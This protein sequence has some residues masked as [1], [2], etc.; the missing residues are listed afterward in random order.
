MSQSIFFVIS[1]FVGPKPPVRIIKSTS[2]KAKSIAFL[3]LF[4]ESPT[5][6]ILKQSI[7]F[8]TNLSAIQ[9]ELEF[10]ICP[11]RISSPI[12]IISAFIKLKSSCWSCYV[13]S[14]FWTNI[15][16]RYRGIV[17]NVSC[18]HAYIFR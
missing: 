6:V 11:I 1:S 17:N 12:V 3:I 10:M 9:E 5:V 4:I 15:N 7:P 14:F 13:F 2:L 16:N 8:F 18:C